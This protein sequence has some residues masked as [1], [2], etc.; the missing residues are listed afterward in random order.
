MNRRPRVLVLSAAIEPPWTRGDRNLVRGIVEHLQRYR[1]TVMTHAVDEALGAEQAHPLVELGHEAVPA[2]GNKREVPPSAWERMRR[3]RRLVRATDADVVHLFWPAELVL[4]LGLAPIVRERGLPLVHTLLR[5]PRT[6]VGI[7]RAVVGDEV[8][9]LTEETLQRVQREGVEHATWV[10]PG[11]RAQSQRSAVDR[12]AI[13]QR[14]G[15]P[16]GEPLVLYAG[17]YRHTFA[18]RTVAATLPR[19]VREV[20]CHFVM[21]CR[22]RDDEDA[23]EEQRIKQAVAAD[24]LA[25]R[26]TW[27]NE[28]D[29]LRAL[30]AVADLQVFPADS[31]HEK[32]DM[33]LVLLEGMAEG[34]ATV[35]ARKPPLTE[36][37]AA[38]AARG[39]PALEPVA[40]AAAIIDLIRDDKQRDALRVRGQKLVTTRFDIAQVAGRYEALYDAARARHAPRESAA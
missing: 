40:L 39:V 18:A 19:V 36:L 17:D 2:W 30:F 1:A 9:C 34:C 24:G 11:I 26:I 5:A 25:D 33:P 4:A 6:T 21:A 3:F 27:L 23:A 38:R 15:L 12:S 10:P 37:V 29:D 35:V 16:A 13:R 28:V 14:Y 31:H 20:D 22:V 8:A 32:M 7:R